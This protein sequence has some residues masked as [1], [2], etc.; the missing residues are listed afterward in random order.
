ERRQ[1]SEEALEGGK[2]DRDL[3]H[4]AR[5][6][7]CVERADQA[8][9][10]RERTPVGESVRV[11][12]LETLLHS[13]RARQVLLSLE[14]EP[15]ESERDRLPSG[16]SDTC[17]QAGDALR[18]SGRCCPCEDGSIGYDQSTPHQAIAAGVEGEQD[19][20]Q[21]SGKAHPEPDGTLRAA[22]QTGGPRGRAR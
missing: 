18:A 6:R 7:G 9:R 4:R 21:W 15:L 14:S 12:G 5:R 13:G 11:A 10:A 8:S 3:E 1:R 2:H 19:R 16:G 20:M 17:A 22:S